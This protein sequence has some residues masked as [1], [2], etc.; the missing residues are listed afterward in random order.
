[1]A[2]DNRPPPHADHVLHEPARA[3][4]ELAGRGGRGR[5]DGQPRGQHRQRV[6]RMIRRTLSP[7]PDWEARL[8][9]VG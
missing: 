9:E 2:P 4:D 1:M 8:R 5:P 7:R 6:R 3:A